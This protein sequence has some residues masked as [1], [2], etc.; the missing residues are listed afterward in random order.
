VLIQLSPTLL[1]WLTKYAPKSDS[2]R[3]LLVAKRSKEVLF[4]DRNEVIAYDVWLRRPWPSKAGKRPSIP[5]GIRAEIKEEAYGSCAMCQSYAGT[6]EA[7]HLDP[8][9]QSKNNH[10]HNL[11][12]LCANHH[13]AYDKGLLGPKHEDR[14]FVQGYKK[15]LQHARLAVWRGGGAAVRRVLTALEACAKL[16]RQAKAAKTSAQ[17]NAVSRLGSRILKD[18]QGFSP[19]LQS[20]AQT[21]PQKAVA[22]RLQKLAKSRKSVSSRLQEASS[23]KAAYAKS[24]GLVT[25]P[26]CGGKGRYQHDDCPVCQGDRMI[27]EKEASAVQLADYAL[28]DCPVCD[29]AGRRGGEA[30]PACGGERKMQRR[31][32]AQIDVSEFREVDCPVCD[33]TGKLRNEECPACGGEKQMDRRFADQINS[34]DYALVKCPL[35]EGSGRHDGEDCPVCRG[36]RRIEKRHADEVDLEQYSE[37]NCPL[38]DGAGRYEGDDCPACGGERM[39]K[40]RAEQIDVREYELVRCP[41]CKGRRIVNG[42]ECLACGGE[43]KLQRRFAE[44]R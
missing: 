42:E 8:V 15:V 20:A 35:C 6:C 28:I 13:T 27:D 22:G 12:W 11:I 38:C 17:K 41:A 36:E 19:G 9:A 18:L 40:A 37:V 2:S 4:F 21:P 10:P 32:A 16:E 24:Y 34:A 39:A 14:A 1:K 29:G 33:G 26:L 30:C 31:L 7:A 43:G 3:K 5:T 44:G 25:C 23:I